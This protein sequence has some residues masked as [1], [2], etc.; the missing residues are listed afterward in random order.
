[1]DVEYI[2][3]LEYIGTRIFKYVSPEYSRNYFM[4]LWCVILKGPREN[5]D[6]CLADSWR[7]RE[8]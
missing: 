6:F 3:A 2:E 7:E 8:L 1:M 5:L 4:R